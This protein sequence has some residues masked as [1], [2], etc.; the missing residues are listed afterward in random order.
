MIKEYLIALGQS[1]IDSVF[2]WIQAEIHNSQEGPRC[3]G[4][5]GSTNPIR[6]GAGA[7]ADVWY[8]LCSGWGVMVG[9]GSGSLP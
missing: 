2:C 5:T 1:H 6:P 8:K 9:G 7:Q 3:S 4:G